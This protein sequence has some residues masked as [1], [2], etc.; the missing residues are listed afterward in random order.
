[1]SPSRA[2]IHLAK[3]DLSRPRG[4]LI[5]MNPEVRVQRNP[6]R[7]GERIAL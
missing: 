2:R 7:T 4:E 1:M 3:F 6:A 5:E